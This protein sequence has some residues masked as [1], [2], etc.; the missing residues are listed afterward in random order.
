MDA[1][2]EEWPPSLNAISESWYRWPFSP[3]TAL[4]QRLENRPAT[5]KQ[6]VLSSAHA[7]WVLLG[8]DNRQTE[9]LGLQFWAEMP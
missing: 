5:G 9:V 3:K 8:P 4:T 2:T 7:M 6:Q 1:Q